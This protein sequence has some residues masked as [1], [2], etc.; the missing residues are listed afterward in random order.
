MKTKNTPVVVFHQLK[1]HFDVFPHVF[2]NSS[3]KSL[4]WLIDLEQR[5]GHPS[6]WRLTHVNLWEHFGYPWDLTCSLRTDTSCRPS[7]G[8]Q[9]SF[10]LIQV[11]KSTAEKENNVVEST[12]LRLSCVVLADFLLNECLSAKAWFSRTIISYLLHRLCMQGLL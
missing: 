12:F 5:G 1:A 8:G 4:L 9:V 7:T 11:F 3:S 10:S 6:H 2:L